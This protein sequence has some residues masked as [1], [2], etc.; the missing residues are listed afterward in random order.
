MRFRVPTLLA[1]AAGLAILGASEARAQDERPTLFSIVDTFGGYDSLAKAVRIAGLEQTLDGPD[2]LTLY[3]PS[4]AAFVALPDFARETLF[5]DPDLLRTILLYHVRDGAQVIPTTPVGLSFAPTLNGASLQ[6]IRVEAGA[7]GPAGDSLL[8]ADSV[9]V[10]IPDVLA[11]NGVFNAIGELL[12]PPS[13]L[14]AMEFSPLHNTFVGALYEADLA[15]GLDAGGPFTV[16]APTDAAFDTLY[17]QDAFAALL[18]DAATLAR[19]LNYHIVNDELTSAD[20]VDGQ[21]LV[22]ASGDTLSVQVTTTGSVFVDGV[23]VAIADVAAF[24]GVV[25]VVGEVLVPDAV[26]P[27]PRPVTVFDVIAGS[28]VHNT[29]ESALAATDLQGDLD[30]A[31]ETY[32]VFAPDDQAFDALPAGALDSLLDDP[33]GLTDLLSYHVVPGSFPSAELADGD[34]LVSLRGDT[35]TL[36]VNANGVFVDGVLVATPDLAADNGVVHS[37]IAVLAPPA[38]PADTTVAD[39]TTSVVDVIAGR[40]DLTTLATAV[41]AADLIEAL[42]DST[43][44]FT[45]F[46]PA[47]SA[48][49]ALPEGTLDSL[50]DDAEGLADLLRYHVVAGT[51]AAA[52]LMD[53]MRLATLQGDSLTVSV[54]SAGVF[55][56]SA[57]VTVPDLTADNGVVHVIGGV[58]TPAMPV[59]TSDGGEEVDTTT[60][61]DVIAESDV[62][63]TLESALIASGLD[64]ALDDSTAMLTVFAP[65]DAAFAALDQDSLS[66]VLDDPTGRLADLLRAHVV[67]GVLTAD[68]LTDGRRLVALSGDTLVVA[69]GAGGAVSVNGVAVTMADLTAGN[70]VV[71]VVGEVLVPAGFFTG[72]IESAADAGFRVYPTVTAGAVRIEAPEGVRVRSVTAVDLGGRA[73]ELVPTGD[74]LDLSGV[75]PGHYFLVLETDGGRY[76]ARVVR[77]E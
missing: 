20:F 35:L 2:S 71:H 65:T 75:A 68:S 4:D 14:E 52:D 59:D 40:D 19:V 58:L 7:E 73:V 42:D 63:A 46:A 18:D 67:A 53:G 1:L 51:F 29:L 38:R 24:N 6:L 26:R 54:T 8:V 17:Q 11:S 72:T 62:H 43:G 5:A 74:V 64:A 60:V 23:P 33:E 44:A 9:G 50:L 36:T 34:E 32:T 70:G 45:V 47:D 56:D 21:E 61:F 3:A 12:L 10:E 49:A 27:L 66:A 28:E 77:A 37:I 30:D 39:T 48:F 25:H 76:A 69:V 13:V 55:V 15:D 31:A 41:E 57:A 16:F 22:T